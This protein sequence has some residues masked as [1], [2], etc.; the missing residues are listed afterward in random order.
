M[1]SDFDE[2]VERVFKSIEDSLD[3]LDMGIE[4]LRQGPVLEIE[5]EDDTKIVVN[6]QGAMREI[7]LAAK[8]GGFHF[9]HSN[10]KWL[11]TRSGDEFF[12]MLSRFASQQA[13]QGVI[14]KA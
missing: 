4:S 10:G 6:S 7:W 1:A 12:G 5:F 11:D 13:G 9:R 14:I 2:Q 8:A 3:A